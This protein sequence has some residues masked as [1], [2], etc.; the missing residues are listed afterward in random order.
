LAKGIG[1]GKGAKST[2]GTGNFNLRSQV[3]M[4]GKTVL[5]Q[6]LIY[7]HPFPP[8]SLQVF[9]RRSSTQYAT[10]KLFCGKK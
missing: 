1:E 8:R 6:S 10:E 9:I 7:R 5:N 2:V 3:R 4:R